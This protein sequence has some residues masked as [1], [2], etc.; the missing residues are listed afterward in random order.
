MADLALP[1]RAQLSN[2]VF[3]KSLR[4][5]DIKSAARRDDTQSTTDD[6]V[7][8]ASEES[9]ENDSSQSAVNL[10]GVDTEHITTF[11][12]YHF[13]LLNGILKLFVF[14]A[15]LLRLMGF[16][17]FAA[18]LLAWAATLPANAW[19]TNILVGQSKTLMGLRDKKL[20]MLNEVLR[21]IRQVKFS[22]LESRWERSVLGLRDKELGV[23]W[24]FFLADTGLGACWIIS[25]ILLAA[26]SLTV[27][28]AI[29]G[30]LLPSVA[31]VSIGMF[32]T[33]ETTLGSLPELVTLGIEFMVSIRRIAAYL[34]GSEV[35]GIE[36]Q[37]SCITF[38]DASIS[39]PVDDGTASKERFGLQSLDLSFPVG[40][41]S[42]I[43]GKTG[44]GKS[45]L[46][47][48]IL[49]EVDILKGAIRV[50]ST[51][52]VSTLDDYPHKDNWI[53]PGSMAYVS[54]NPW[55]T[56]TSVRE[57][58]LFGLP[59]DRTRYNEVIEACALTEDLA[60]LSDGHETDLGSNGVNLS[61]GQKWRLTLAR[62]VYSR[63]EIL[64]MEDIFSAVDTH[65][66]RWI[67][68]QCL[69]G[70][71][72][73]GR[74]RILVTHNLGLV[75]SKAGYLVE[76]GEGGRV[77]QAGS[78]RRDAIEVRVDEEE[79]DAIANASANKSGSVP[80]STH[81]P[82]AAQP[83]PP[84]ALPDPEAKTKR[85]FM[86]DETRQK[87]IV[88]KQ[89]YKT[90]VKSSGNVYLWIICALSF[91]TYEAGIIGMLAPARE[92]G[93]SVLTSN[94][95]SLVVTHLDCVLHQQR[96]RHARSQCL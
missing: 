73:E 92:S 90:Y 86:Q 15:F 31:F 39:W 77:T 33:L 53:I 96:G 72:C 87:G 78:P 46:L 58:I 70:R 51:A 64:I 21:G 35:E 16:L 54:Q 20:A 65:V 82:R 71:L 56:S 94:R 19:F 42:V 29:H 7:K 17:P 6:E 12:Q 47:S 22:A 10:V 79:T 59:F 38:E 26:T 28:V 25:P 1:I 44:T 43:S 74:T 27:Y 8:E 36:A 18:G 32:N 3:S 37:G 83:P 67:F 91:L 2:L 45:L 80:E 41:I 85:K 5:K 13:L 69:T 93:T 48:A 62:A 84:N 66:G 52:Q 88:G 11:A 55:L 40:Q 76:L 61:G 95:S 75:L 60:A 57:N 68:E 81:I 49:G 4:R 34:D 89:I 30:H 50:P 63:A 24:K 23:L 14:S 9:I